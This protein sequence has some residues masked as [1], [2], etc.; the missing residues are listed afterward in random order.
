MNG[1]NAQAATAWSEGPKRPDPHAGSKGGV[2]LLTLADLRRDYPAMRPAVVAGLLRRG[3]VCNIIAPP[4]VGKSWAAHDLVLAVA[5]GGMWMGTFKCPQ[6]SA[7][8]LDNEL[9]PEVL[10]NRIGAVAHARGYSAEAVARFRVAALRGYGLSVADLQSVV[11]G[12]STDPPDL[13][14]LDALYRALPEN[15]S[16]NDN[17][18]MTRVYNVVDRL[19]RENNAAVVLVHHST[20]GIQAGRAVT[21]VG[22][23]A[24]A[25]SRAADTHLILRPHREDGAAVLDAVARSWPPPAAQCFRWR[26]P[27]WEPA[28]DLDPADLKE[29]HGRGDPAAEERETMTP[30]EFAQRFASATPEPKEAILG[31]AVAA[32]WKRHRAD[33]LFRAAQGGNFL[34]NHTTAANKPGKYATVPP[35]FDGNPV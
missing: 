9:Y 21:D 24:G 3:E 26:Y 29:S 28:P 35:G 12:A 11:E 34:F 30:D 16:E 14:V 4:K 19:A 25:I 31:R 8:L 15:T 27:I 23:G 10:S 2:P 6:G 22:S 7:L 32:G 20:K 17:A 18:E 33:A 5:S 1:L 13:I